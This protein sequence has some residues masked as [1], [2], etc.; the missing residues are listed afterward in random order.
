MGR[1]TRVNELIQRELSEQLHTFYR[2]QSVCFT[3]TEVV[4]SPNLR[5]ARVYYSVLGDSRV[6]EQAAAFFKKNQV[7][8]RAQMAKKVILKYLPKL[9]F[10]YHD[11]IERGCNVVTLLDQLDHE[12]P[13][14]E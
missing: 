8:M 12:Q 1:L 9:T 13:P 6:K 10:V 14:N 2:D 7:S 4:T 11:S 3:I 5:E